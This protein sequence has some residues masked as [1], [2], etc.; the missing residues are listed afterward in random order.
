MRERD[1]CYGKNVKAERDGR[2]AEK[3][4]K[5]GKVCTRAYGTRRWKTSWQER[6]REREREQFSL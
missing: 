4:E 2:R 6:G 3:R 1:G 5:W